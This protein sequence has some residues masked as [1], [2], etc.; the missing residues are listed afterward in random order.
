MNPATNQ[1][2]GFRVF[3]A[4]MGGMCGSGY[5][6]ALHVLEQSD[7][8]ALAGDW[9]RISQDWQSVLTQVQEKADEEQGNLFTEE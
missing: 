7:A 8:Q 1:N 3:L 4:G 6:Y 9:Q 5:E 2:R